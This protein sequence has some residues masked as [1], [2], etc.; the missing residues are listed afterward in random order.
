MADLKK[1]IREIAEIAKACPE[2]FR[3]KC[4]EIL[5]NDA[6]GRIGEP[7]GPASKK[8]ETSK[9]AGTSKALQDFCRKYSV[10]DGAVANVFDFANP[11]SFLQV[12][13]F[14]Q[15][16]KSKQ[17][18][19]IGLLA[20]VYALQERGV[21]VIKDDAFRDLCEKH[22]VYDK[23]NFAKHMK[24]YKKYFIGSAEDDWKLTAVGLKKAAE[25]INSLG[26]DG[27]EFK[28]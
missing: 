22:Q 14:G 8:V 10:T 7:Q 2:E 27:A 15:N 16:T 28:L 6:L 1:E 12:S 24:S 17:Q 21:P 26:G 11:E 4:F 18:I 23:N 13:D 25:V 20:A 9:S 19:A 3:Q 5:L